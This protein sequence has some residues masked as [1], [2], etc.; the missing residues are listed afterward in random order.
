MQRI[1]APSSR[2]GVRT[3]RAL[4][5]RELRS[6]VTATCA[7]AFALMAV[8]CASAPAPRARDDLSWRARLDAL[9]AMTARGMA[10]LT[11]EEVRAIWPDPLSFDVD[12][13]G[14]LVLCSGTILLEDEGWK[15]GG[16]L[17]FR[18]VEFQFEPHRE[19]DRGPCTARLRSISVRDHC[20]TLEEAKHSG[21]QLTRAVWPHQAPYPTA[22]GQGNDPKWRRAAEWD[23]WLK[24]LT[25]TFGDYPP[26]SGTVEIVTPR[27]TPSGQKASASATAAARGRKTSRPPR[28]GVDRRASRR[29]RPAQPRRS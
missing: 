21:D 26:T 1:K 22:S 4:S 13:H 24:A 7:A 2:R 14:A 16:D 17:P 6:P 18:G 23:G 29:R 25:Y 3:L 10:G 19:T 5:T 27:P 12:P 8:A 9:K 11:P 15:A 28:R 20:P